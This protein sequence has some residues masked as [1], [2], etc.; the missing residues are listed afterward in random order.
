M[1]GQGR[2]LGD[3]RN[4]GQASKDLGMKVVQAAVLIMRD[5]TE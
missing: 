2:K 4:A 5:N 1:E 3:K